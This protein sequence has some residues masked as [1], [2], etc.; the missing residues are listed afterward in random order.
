MF[1]DEKDGFS[2]FQVTKVHKSVG[3]GTVSSAEQASHLN[4]ELYIGRK[5]PPKSMGYIGVAPRTPKEMHISFF[6][7]PI[8]GK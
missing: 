8:K 6:Y 2:D 3:N 4:A 5:L 1:P 7:Y